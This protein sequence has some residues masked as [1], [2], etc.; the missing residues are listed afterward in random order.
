MK[1]VVVHLFYELPNVF[2]DKYIYFVD[3]E[4]SNLEHE[5]IIYNS[6]KFNAEAY[7]DSKFRFYPLP[8]ASLGKFRY[9]LKF[10]HKRE[11]DLL[12]IHGLFYRD[13]DIVFMALVSRF[14]NI[15]K[16]TLWSM[17]GGDIYS[18]Q[19]PPE[20]FL[21]RVKFNIE[22]FF[23]KETIQ[24]IAFSTTIVPSQAKS[25]NENYKVEFQPYD[26]FY[27]NPLKFEII[28]DIKSVQ[29]NFG[30]DKKLVLLG[31]SASPSNNHLLG[32]ELLSEFVGKISVLC[33]MAYGNDEYRQK[34]I[35]EGNKIFAEDFSCQT[36]FLEPE[37]YLHK[38]NHVDCALFVHDRQQALG[39]IMI[40]LCLGKKVFM[41]KEALHYIFLKNLGFSVFA[42]EDLSIE[43]FSD[44]TIDR[45]E[46]YRKVI[47]FFSDS[48]AKDKWANVFE[49]TI[50]RTREEKTLIV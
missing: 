25:L 35:A 50:A 7:K 47:R 43:I 41:K 38:L 22:E 2:N 1:K 17:W 11:F 33:P 23:K 26:A 20:S 29:T 44:V 15:G 10:F 36:Q 18:F 32:L 5:A 24:K 9:L 13:L 4:F 3:D 45:N 37:A 30:D 6:K 14:T 27:P 12:I 8:E 49:R 34:V 21:R 40:L 46:E 16:K 48:A 42:I 28:A 19:L 39:N 31:N